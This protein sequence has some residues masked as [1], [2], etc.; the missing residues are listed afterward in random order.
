MK[1]IHL[2]SDNS[3]PQT[4]YSAYEKAVIKR[5]AI[6]RTQC[7]YLIDELER[8]GLLDVAMFSKDGDMLWDKNPEQEVFEML[9]WCFC[10][11]SATQ[12][13]IDRDIKAFLDECIARGEGLITKPSRMRAV[14]PKI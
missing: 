10:G 14:R 6:A 1:K 12:T 2:A 5:L 13:P 4:V 11:W 8:I 7:F 3:Q 9:D